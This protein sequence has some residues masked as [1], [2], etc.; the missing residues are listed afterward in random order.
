MPSFIQRIIKRYPVV[1]MTATIVVCFGIQGAFTFCTGKKC[2]GFVDANF[3]AWF[4]YQGSDDLIFTNSNGNSDTLSSFNNSRT[5]EYTTGAFEGRTCNASAYYS[6]QFSSDP[7]S[8]FIVHATT[9]SSG[10][11]YYLVLKALTLDITAV[12]DAGGLQFSSPSFTETFYNNYQVNGKIF[13]NVQRITT[14]TNNIKGLNIR[15]FFLAKN[16]GLVA[17]EEYPSGIIWVKR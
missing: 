16:Q 15:E 1:V 17:Y 2:P 3:D 10:T 4:P 13:A 8:Q 5:S 11:G 6:W 7:A 9:N 14:D 12:T